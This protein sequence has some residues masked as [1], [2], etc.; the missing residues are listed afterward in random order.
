MNRTHL[1]ALLLWSRF[2]S[3]AWGQTNSACVT[4]NG[5]ANDDTNDIYPANPLC[6]PMVSD[7]YPLSS[8]TLTK[9]GLAATNHHVSPTAFLI[10]SSNA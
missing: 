9:R 5:C 2:I 10:A 8:A 4:T 3:A 7:Q 6:Y 1:L